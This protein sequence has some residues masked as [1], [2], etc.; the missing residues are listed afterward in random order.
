[1]AQEECQLQ[2]VLLGNYESI[3]FP[4]HSTDHHGSLNNS[5]VETVAGCDCLTAYLSDSE[6][7]REE[8]QKYIHYAHWH[9]HS[10]CDLS[11][12]QADL[13]LLPALGWTCSL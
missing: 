5:H 9:H 8:E 10:L 6:K 2:I 4:G 13:L 7:P 3:V 1:M 12:G 11:L